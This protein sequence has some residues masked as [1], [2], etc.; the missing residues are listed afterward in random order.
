MIAASAASASLL[1][2]LLGADILT[3][4]SLSR[5]P[6]ADA[7]HVEMTAQQWWWE[8]RY[9]DALG[10]PQF[11]VSSELHVPVGRPVIVSLKSTDVIH[12]F[13]VPSLHGKKD[14]LPGR[15]TQLVM[16]ADQ[17]G[18]YRGECAEFCGMEHAL[19]AFSV[20]A[21]PP[22]DYARW[23]AAQRLPPRSLRLAIWVWPR[24]V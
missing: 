11:A 20:T 5:L 17:A 23:H 15:P 2:V 12:T 1:A 4:R 3:D 18:T 8:A 9:L 22:Q 13:W 24:Y 19:M 10:R 6:V 16:Q 21:E 14:M 7:L